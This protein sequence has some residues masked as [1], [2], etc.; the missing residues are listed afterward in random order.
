LTCLDF[1]IHVE[2]R[3][4]TLLSAKAEELGG[5]MARVACAAALFFSRNVISQQ[6]SP[7]RLDVS[8]ASQ[9]AKNAK[10]RLMM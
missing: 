6:R 3:I 8:L 4:S 2:L 10:D 1:L 9:K 7:N 5:S